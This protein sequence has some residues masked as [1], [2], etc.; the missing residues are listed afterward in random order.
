MA[1]EAECE[2]RGISMRQPE[3]EH[4]FGPIEPGRYA[5]WVRRCVKCGGVATVRVPVERGDAS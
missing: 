4:E 2:V 3:C 5:R 1:T